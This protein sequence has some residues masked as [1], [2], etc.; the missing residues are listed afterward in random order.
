MKRGDLLARFRC[1]ERDAIAEVA[2]LARLMVGDH[3]YYVAPDDRDDVVQEILIDVHRTVS[4]PE[5]RLHKTF[6]ALVRTIAHRRCVDWIRRRRPDGPSEV[7]APS[8]DPGPDRVLLDR[9]RS[10]LGARVL[11]DLGPSCRRLVGLHVG[12]GLTYRAIAERLGRSELGVR[13]HMHKCIR[14]ARDLLVRLLDDPQV[15]S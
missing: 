9:E 6:E 13:V 10:W 1:G 3:G 12:R 4:S 8:S 15:S 2:R 11:H 5:F 14:R 7:D